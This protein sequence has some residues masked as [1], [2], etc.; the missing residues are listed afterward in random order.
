MNAVNWPPSNYSILVFLVSMQS[1]KLLRIIVSPQSMSVEKF[2]DRPNQ[3]KQFLL[4]KIMEAKNPE[5]TL[6][7]FKE[8]IAKVV[9][10]K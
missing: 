2:F 9:N 6:K 5:K 7:S 4:S 8:Y 3:E 10:S 1:N